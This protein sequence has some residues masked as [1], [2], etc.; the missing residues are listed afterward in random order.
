MRDT[1][2]TPTTPVEPLDP[3]RPAWRDVLVFTGKQLPS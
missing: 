3:A 2:K 1:R